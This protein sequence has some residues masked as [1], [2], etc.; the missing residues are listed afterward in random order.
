MKKPKVYF[1]GGGYES[2]YYVR[3]LIPMLANLWDGDKTSRS[4]GRPDSSKMLQGA[5]HADIVVFH[6]P[7][8]TKMIEAA[9]LLKQA[10]KKIVMDNDDTYTRDSGVPLQMLSRLK[11]E[12]KEKIND[13]DNTL[14][15]FAGIADMV[16]VST[17]TLA[18]EYEPYNKNVIVLKNT[19][20]KRD[21]FKPKEKRGDKVR[22][23]IVGSVASNQDYKQIIPLLDKLKD[24]DDVQLVLFALPQLTEHTKLA[25]E[26][27][28]PE[29]EFW[30]KYN[31][32]W[33]HFVHI[34]EYNKKLNDLQLDIMLIPR[35]DS[36]FNRAK[37][38]LKFL[39]ASMC[40][41]PVIAQGFTTGDS[42]Y[43]GKD[44][45]YM[46]I[47]ITDE[48]WETK[49]FDLI[50]NKEKR[51]KLSEKAYTY[52]VDNYD[53]SNNKDLWTEAYQK[54]W[55]DTPIS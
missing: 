50:N 8:D 12:L 44:E 33:H 39:E 9:K 26:M 43:Q 28:K 13:I 31:P 21:W 38:N 45:E 4:V 53:I 37:S 40:K 17:E 36:Y 42:P 11:N 35:Y 3:C 34:S 41:I 16:T 32:E 1:I 15:E 6:R 19:V 48:D 54:I 27:Y 47:C 10:G 23:G 14:K 7:M 55:N 24:K 5:M 18:K 49:T 2:C 51:D 46:E 29:Y 20:D 25:V 52:V 30:H 22:I